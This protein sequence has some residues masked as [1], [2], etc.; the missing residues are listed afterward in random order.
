MPSTPIPPQVI[1]GS[2]SPAWDPSSHMPGR[3][4]SENN[5]CSESSQPSI[6]IRKLPGKVNHTK[7]G[8]DHKE[9][10][11]LDESM[12]EEIKVCHLNARKRMLTYSFLQSYVHSL[13]DSHLNLT[14]PWT[15]QDTSAQKIV[16]TKV[17][18]IHLTFISD[19]YTE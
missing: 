6:L 7:G 9:S 13:I 18:Y 16:L 3:P 17:S 1:S 2:V 12:Y 5:P 19:T 11:R 8:Y 14:Q 10:M 4:S 15:K